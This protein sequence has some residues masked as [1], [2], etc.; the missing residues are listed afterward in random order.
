MA[1]RNFSH[2]LTTDA[3]PEDLWSV[4]SDLS[5]WSS[6]NTLT[7]VAPDGVRVGGA[8]RLRIALGPFRLPARARI[9]EVAPNQRLTRAGGV[10][11]LFTAVHGFE[12][13]PTQAGGTKIR[14]HEAF[15]GLLVGPV[16]AL[17]GAGHAD[18]YGRVNVG[19]A[20]VA[21]AAEAQ[22]SSKSSTEASTSAPVDEL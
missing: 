17:L 15:R 7:G 8:L 14:H 22:R 4:L 12:L 19:L 21:L 20:D 16:L 3:P 5:S 6:W 10:P 1:E 13:T 2:E 11:G 18:M 9:T